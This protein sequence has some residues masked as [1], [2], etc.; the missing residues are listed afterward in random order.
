M[1]VY[2]PWVPTRQLPL[3]PPTLG[4]VLGCTD[5]W[6]S[7]LVCRAFR[8]A[9]PPGCVDAATVS[10]PERLELARAAAGWTETKDLCDRAAAKG[11]LAVL[12]WARANGCRWTHRTCDRAAAN[13]H[14]AVLQWA[15]ANGCV[16]TH[17]SCDWAAENGHLAVLQWA[18]ANGCRWTSGT[19]DRAAAN[20]HLAVLQWATQNGCESGH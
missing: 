15:R 12:Q 9:A 17:R 11:H 3:D 1:A 16:W 8:T 20:G 14:L 19:C 18:R 5:A 13:G 6:L 2:D 4:L 10:S 7:R